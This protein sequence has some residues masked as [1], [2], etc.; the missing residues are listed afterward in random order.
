MRELSKTDNIFIKFITCYFVSF[1]AFTLIK[2]LL[3]NGTLATIG[4]AI[5]AFPIM[6]KRMVKAFFEL[7]KIKSA[8]IILMAISIMLIYFISLLRGVNIRI[9]VNY[10][11]F[12]FIGIILGWTLYLIEDLEELYDAFVRISK[13][14]MLLAV[15]IIFVDRNIIVYSMRYSYL[16]S[17]A[18]YFHTNEFIEGEKKNLPLI[19]IE[20]LLILIFGSRGPIL[21]F[22][23]FLCLKI[24]LKSKKIGFKIVLI[25]LGGAF[26][27]F[28]DLIGK[29]VMKVLSQYGI[30]SR[31]LS[32]IFTQLFYISKRDIIAEECISLIKQKPIIGWGCA[33]EYIKMTA[34]PHNIILELQLDFG[35][36]FGILF[37]CL[38]IILI[39]RI[40]LKERGRK[41]DLFLIF[42]SYG[43]VVLF[44]SG[45]YLTWDGFPMMLGLMFNLYHRGY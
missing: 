34:Y 31:T 13:W 10:Y 1:M 30:Q 17:M 44:Y 15:L 7:M 23:I 3:G 35:I 6:F 39:V 18:L 37:F 26:I 29:E 36:I 38:L 27:G 28:Y 21:C 20:L 12:A 24:L 33:G 42:V 2:R 19:I 9:I 43:F 4:A 25:T 11:F 41:S 16:L 14:I 22:A 40:I 32:L 8:Q 45:T 5:I